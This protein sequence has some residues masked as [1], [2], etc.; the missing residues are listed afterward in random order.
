M[1][2]KSA[3]SPWDLN[4]PVTV[5]SVLLSAEATQC[6]SLAGSK[7]LQGGHEQVG[8]SEFNEVAVL[9]TVHTPGVFYFLDS[10]LYFACSLL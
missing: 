8:V 4:L 10:V 1:P 7:E 6:S 5:L 9:N 3:L 2:K